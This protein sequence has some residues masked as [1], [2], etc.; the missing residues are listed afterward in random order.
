MIWSK[1]TWPSGNLSLSASSSSL[2]L[3]PGFFF[4]WLQCGLESSCIFC[5]SSSS[6]SSSSSRFMTRSSCVNLF[7][8]SDGVSST[9]SW[10]GLTE[11][12]LL[13]WCILYRVFNLENWIKKY[14]LRGPLT[15][16]S[17]TSLEVLWVLMSCILFGSWQRRCQYF[18]L[19]VSKNND[20]DSHP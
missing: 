10:A 7:L 9:G 18:Y 17:Q 3:G 20:S 11:A 19:S 16:C 1:L 8:N 6:F 13:N 15:S 14:R 5:C 4:W 12:F 2:F